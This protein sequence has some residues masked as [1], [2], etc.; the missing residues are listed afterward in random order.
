[1]ETK[2]WQEK[3]F[4]DIEFYV[5]MRHENEVVVA[6]EVHSLQLHDDG[7]GR[8]YKFEKR[9]ATHSGEVTTDPNDSEPYVKGTIKW[10]GCS[11]VNFLGYIHAC[12][13]QELVRFGQLFDRLFN[14]A[15]ELMPGNG[16]Y[17]T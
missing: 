2:P 17:L 10:D 5:R 12:S 9:G 14:F 8:P 1:M 11:H 4:E 16:E 15:M 3:W 6:F 7:K 13:R